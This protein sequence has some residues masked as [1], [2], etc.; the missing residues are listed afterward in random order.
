MLI[1][2][3]DEMIKHGI[4]KVWFHRIHDISNMIILSESDL[5]ETRFVRYFVQKGSKYLFEIIEQK[6]FGYSR[7]N[8]DNAISHN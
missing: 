1:H 4:Y 3:L 6:G 8:A 2:G 7:Y 5:F